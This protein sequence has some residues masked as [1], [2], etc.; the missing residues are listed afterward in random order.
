M[1]SGFSEGWSYRP[2]AVAS[3]RTS[4]AVTSGEMTSAKWCPYASM[5]VWIGFVAPDVGPNRCLHS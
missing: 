1:S 4:A 5:H 2:L 3:R